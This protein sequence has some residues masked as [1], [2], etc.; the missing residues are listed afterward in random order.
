MVGAD[1]VCAAERVAATFVETRF[2]SG[3][4]RINGKLQDVK[5]KARS[6][7]VIIDFFIFTSLVASIIAFVAMEKQQTWLD[8]AILYNSLYL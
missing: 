7:N 6:T 2:I 8:H 5:R 1:W 4:S 3:V